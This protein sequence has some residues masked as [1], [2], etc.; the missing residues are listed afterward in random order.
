[1]I[2]TV[3]FYASLWDP[4]LRAFSFPKEDLVLQ[5]RNKILKK[6]AFMAAVMYRRKKTPGHFENY[7]M[8]LGPSNFWMFMGVSNVLSENFIVQVD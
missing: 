3:V 5:V 8:R 7:L 1:M 4:A 2:L 6:W